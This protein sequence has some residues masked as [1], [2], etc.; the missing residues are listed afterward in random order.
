MA[1]AAEIL[2]VRRN[3]GETDATSTYTD[4]TLTAYIDALGVLGATVAV[5]EEKAASYAELVDTSE[6]GAS[7]RLSQLHDNALKQANF[8]SGKAGTAPGS[9]GR[10]RVH[11]IQRS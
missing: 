2:Q 9:G 3:T 6:A 11:T 10:A 7:R 1:T 4:L 5:W 8:W